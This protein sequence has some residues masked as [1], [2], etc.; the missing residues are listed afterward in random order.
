MRFLYKLKLRQMIIILVLVPVIAMSYFASQQVIKEVKSNNAMVEL[1][2]FITLSVNLS[3]LV[4][5]Q[6]KERGATAVFL[7]SKGKEFADGM[8][9]QRLETNKMRVKLDEYLAQFDAET[10]SETFRSDL[11]ALV[12]ETSKLDALRVQVDSLS[13]PLGNAI[14]YFTNLNAQN[15]KFID[16]I[17]NQ[18]VDA[19]ITSRF[20][21][22]TSF[23]QSKERAGIERAVASGQVAS[24][25]FSDKTFAKFKRLIIVQ[26]IYNRVFLTQATPPQIDLFNQTMASPTVQTV[27]GM[28]DVILAGGLTGEFNGLTGEKWFT[29]IT[30]KINLLK[31]IE[32]NLSESLLLAIDDLEVKSATNMWVAGG[33]TL[34][35]LFL[36]AWLSFAFIRTINKSFALII[37]RMDA[38]AQG[39]LNV[40]LPEV[41]NNEIGQML[42]SVHIFK[43]SAIEKQQ[44]EQN[45]EKDKHQAELDKREMMNQLA[46]NFD[47]N[48]GSI[49]ETVAQASKNLEITAESMANISKATSENAE[50]VFSASDIA[51]SNVQSVAAAS[52]EMSQSIVEINNHVSSASQASK[53][54]VTEV[55]KTSQEMKLLAETVEKIGGVVSLISTIAEQTNLLALNATIESARAGEAGRGFAVVASEVKDL[56][57]KTSAATEEI[58]LHIND[59]ER[60]ANQAILSM[61]GIENAIG[62]VEEIS[63]TI[64]EAMLEQSKATAEISENAQKAANGTHEVSQ[65]ISEVTD[66]S[67]RANSASQEVMTSAKEL[68]SQSGLLKSE[69]KKFTEKVRIS[70]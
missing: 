48:L 53:D 22:Y 5:E 52:E 27:Q 64:N 42:K 68:I 15:I 2:G 14:A 49:V 60:V 4:H 54:A 46:D 47:A 66:A 13:I 30:K 32:N 1:A 44:L 31:A 39:D 63:E 12:A 56:A 35:C 69:V 29:A 19:Q 6:Q 37:S 58:S 11:N 65:N 3:N 36:V 21:G 10:Q 62:K 17:G 28:R 41:T 38:L 67:G 45:Q 9:A 59:I 24:G 23:L 40:K 33:A 51:N 8:A 61:T 7:G 57:S 20:I 55:N 34:F 16:Y 50:N 70:G 25:K 26:D 18:S 43:D